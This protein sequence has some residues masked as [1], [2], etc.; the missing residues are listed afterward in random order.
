MLLERKMRIRV[1]RVGNPPNR[2]AAPLLRVLVVAALI[3]IGVLPAR[4]QL[5]GAEPSWQV[6][7]NPYLWIPGVSAKIQTPLPQRPEVRTDVSFDRLLAKLNGVP[8]EGAAELRYGR[9]GLLGDFIHL[10]VA[11]NI[12]TR[13][14]FFQGGKAAETTNTGTMILFYRGLDSPEQ[15]IDVGAG[16]RPWG[17]SATMT[18]NPGLLSRRVITRDVSWADP[19]IAARYHRELGNGFGVT[20]Y[21]DIGGFG[22]GAD[23]DW[24]LL[25][26]VDYAYNSSV[27]FHA[28]YRS[29]HFDYQPGTRLGVNVHLDGPIFWRDHPLL[30]DAG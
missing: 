30:S 19:L 11:A 9:F 6:L 27:S 12:P 29:I 4:A 1:R 20:G 26:T 24:Q 5:A 18:L 23:L 21:A 16:V 10:P 25:G 3:N 28:G 14:V 8:F 13:D 2:A 7:V 15:Y 17:F 22:I